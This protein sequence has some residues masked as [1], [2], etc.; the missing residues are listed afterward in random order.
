MPKGI[1]LETNGVLTEAG[2]AQ[3][4]MGKAYNSANYDT[5][6]AFKGTTPIAEKAPEAVNP[7]KTTANSL[8]DANSLLAQYQK[9]G[10]LS[11]DQML[12]KSPS[13][14]KVAPATA[15]PIAPAPQPIAPAPTPIQQGYQA[16]KSLGIAAPPT[17]GAAGAIMQQNAPPAEPK[18]PLPS[19]IDQ[20]PELQGIIQMA[21][22]FLAP[23]NQRDTLTQEY[24]RLTKASG[25]QALDTQLLNMKNVIEGTEDDLRTEI[26]KAGGFATDSQV[27]ALTN[28]RNKQLIKNYNNLLETRNSAQQHLDTMMNLAVQDRQ[29]A[30]QN[31]DRMMNF[32]FQILNYRDKMQQNAVNQYNKIAETAGY[33]GLMKMTASDPNSV[34]MIENTLGISS[35]GLAQLAA[36]D[37]KKRAQQDLLQNLDIQAKRAAIANAGQVNLQVIKGDDGTMYS[38]NPKTGVLVPF[39]ATKSGTKSALQ[40]AEANSAIEKTTSLL[41]HKGLPGTVGPNPLARSYP[42]FNFFTG[43]RQGFIA[44]VQKL[45][46]GLTVKTLQD[47]KANGATFGALQNKELTLLAD[48]ASTINNWAIHQDGDPEKPVI[49]YN[50]NETDFKNEIQR[51]N[52]FAKLDYLIKGGNPA[53]IGAN[54]MPDGTIWGV[55]WTGNLTQIA[56]VDHETGEIT[57]K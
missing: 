20:S 31:F 2:K 35:G 42:D 54:V 57:G 43:V 56:K 26:T 44:E 51:I 47:A 38:F 10:P 50:A 18:N 16:V 9:S 1:R 53:E 45:T 37:A 6:G 5:S 39:Q 55:D 7:N 12:G 25:V 32:Q 48:S 13:G 11:L 29:L 41:G 28:A 3:Q 17:A 14:L 15:Q 27:M 24:Q 33:D 8:P 36:I 30:S 40:L 23:Q 52:N 4:T 22:Q 19:I 49:G 21:Q 46:S 34:S